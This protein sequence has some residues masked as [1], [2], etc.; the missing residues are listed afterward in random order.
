MICPLSMLLVNLEELRCSLYQWEQQQQ[1]QEGEDRPTGGLLWMAANI[2]NSDMTFHRIMQSWKVMHEAQLGVGDIGG[3]LHQHQPVRECSLPEI[4]ELQRRAPGIVAGT[5]G[6]TPPPEVWRLDPLS[7]S[8][9]CG[10]GGETTWCRGVTAVPSDRPELCLLS[11]RR[12]GCDGMTFKDGHCYLH[13]NNSEFRIERCDRD[14]W[15]QSLG[16]MMLYGNKVWIFFCEA[17]KPS[18]YR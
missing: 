13:Q 2:D 1:A 15:Y 12:A 8:G 7:R 14:S 6:L 5:T 10:V 9:F 16:W 11:A 18:N 3:H 17:K 4:R